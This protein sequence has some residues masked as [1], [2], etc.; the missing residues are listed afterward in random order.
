[1]QS[2]TAPITMLF[3]TWD[4]TVHQC[5]QYVGD[6][7]VPNPAPAIAVHHPPCV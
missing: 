6:A 3:R 5:M 4:P 7:R 1:V 2:R